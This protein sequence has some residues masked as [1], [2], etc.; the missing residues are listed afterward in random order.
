V[1]ERSVGKGSETP[2]ASLRK[3]TIVISGNALVRYGFRDDGHPLRPIRSKISVDPTA[4]P[5]RMDDDA[6]IGL[7]VRRRPGI[8]KLEG[9]RLTLC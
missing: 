3:D 1:Y 6:D 7:S 2:V 5:K 4:S 9:D 8:Y